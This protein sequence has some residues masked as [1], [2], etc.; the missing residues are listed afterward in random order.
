MEVDAVKLCANE[1]YNQSDDWMMTLLVSEFDRLVIFLFAA[2]D[3]PA[4]SLVVGHVTVS[5]AIVP[6]GA[7]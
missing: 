2:K 4:Y 6:L 3:L 7:F 1:N 5:Q